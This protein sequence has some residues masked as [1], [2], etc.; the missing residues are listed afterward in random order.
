MSRN[1]DIIKIE[2]FWENAHSNIKNSKAVEWYKKN[3]L[4]ED[5]DSSISYNVTVVEHNKCE[6]QF[7]SKETFVRAH[8]MQPPPTYEMKTSPA[9]IMSTVSV[10]N[11]G[12]SP[13]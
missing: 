8:E 3:V 12:K 10:C 6:E 13:I 4:I 2:V 5:I 7:T 9:L 1:T 11:E